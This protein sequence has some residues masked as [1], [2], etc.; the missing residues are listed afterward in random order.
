[1]TGCGRRE[2]MGR[3]GLGLTALA[4]ATRGAAA[5]TASRPNVVIITTDDMGAHVGAYGDPQARTPCLDAMAREGML[6]RKAFAP[7]SSCSPCRSAI[8]TGLYPHQS[9]Q[10]GLSQFGYTMDP[11]LPTIFTE[12]KAAGYRTG[13]FG[14]VHVEPGDEMAASWDVHP[15]GAPFTSK[16]EKMGGWAEGFMRE[17]GDQPFLLYY[18]LVD[19]HA[20][21]RDQ[22]EGV[23]AEPRGPDEFTPWP[24]I[25]IEGCA[26]P[27]QQVA[28]YYNCV[29]RAD[30]GVGYLMEALKATGHDEDTLVIFVSDG[31]PGFPRAK[32]HNY[33]AGTQMPFIVRWPGRVSPG[34]QRDE[35]VSAIDIA[36]TVYEVSGLRAPRTLPGR[37]LGPIFRGGNPRWRK[38]V[39]TEHTAHCPHQY[40]PRRAVCDGRFLLIW[41]LLGGE[42]ENPYPQ[43][44]RTTKIIMDLILE[45]QPGSDLAEAVRRTVNPP[46]FEMFDLAEDPGELYNVAE[47]PKYAGKRLELERVLR[48]WMKNTDDPLIDPAKLKM[49]TDW[50][51]ELL[52]HEEPKD[53]R[54]RPPYLQVDYVRPRYKAL[55]KKLSG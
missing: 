11:G 52:T 41:N 8:L 45:K 32:T 12:L 54:G 4:G 44:D 51:D 38:Y 18:N 1:M 47:D 13:W 7:Q 25:G 33:R 9:G 22:I 6:F 29:E 15:F 17:C 23:P 39:F 10:I 31:G 30:R 5:R 26:R 40:F 2:F 16:V 50:H 42:R 3:A 35:L 24:Y 34:V 46:A 43:G 27:D 28:S 53:E 14:K 20:P 36:P 21:Y 49:M 37:S 19:P 55:K 48:E